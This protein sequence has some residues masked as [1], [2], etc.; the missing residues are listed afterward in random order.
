MENTKLESLAIAQVVIRE[1]A[2]AV[3]E[4]AELELAL[5]GGG[6]GETIL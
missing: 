6:M 5:V 2:T 3:R 1:S 4:L